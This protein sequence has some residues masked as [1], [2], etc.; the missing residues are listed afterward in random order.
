M[1][2]RYYYQ[3]EDHQQMIAYVTYHRL[4]NEEFLS[5]C[6]P[7][8]SCVEGLMVVNNE[9]CTSDIVNVIITFT[10]IHSVN[11]SDKHAAQ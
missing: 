3:L 2:P 8:N 4:R 10:R 1:L 6:L 7:V 11:T 5:K 9:S